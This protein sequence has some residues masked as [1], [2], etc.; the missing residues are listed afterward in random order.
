MESKTASSWA[1]CLWTSASSAS[2]SA[3][4]RV[5]SAT[6]RMSSKARP[7]ASAAE[8][9]SPSK[10]VPSLRTHRTQ[11]L[12]PGGGRWSAAAERGSSGSKRLARSVPQ[13]SDSAAP[14]SVHAAG[15]APRIRPPG[16]VRKTASPLVAKSAWSLSSR[17]R[18]AASS[19]PRG[20]P[21]SR[22]PASAAASAEAAA[23]ANAPKATS[24]GAGPTTSAHRP[25]PRSTGTGAQ[26][27][28]RRTRLWLC[29]GR[30]V[31]RCPSFT[32]FTLDEGSALARAI[33]R[34]LEGAR[35]GARPRDARASPGCAGRLSSMLHRSAPNPGLS[36]GRALGIEG[37][38][39]R[40]APEASPP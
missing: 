25:T 2:R 24:H 31:C 22:D 40:A 30:A 20:G 21:D 36:A 39:C 5:R 29:G 3:S 26:V 19:A 28:A 14:N 35:P 33:L 13:S 17:S 37:G 1:V 11:A 34:G 8:R 9:I 4:A 7:P 18:S 38:T 27:S 16:S 6:S 23:R 15:L 32:S 12:S 10:P